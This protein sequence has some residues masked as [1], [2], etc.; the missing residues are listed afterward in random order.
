M[1]VI[2]G[3]TRS[4]VE[5]FEK[6][7][8]L[9]TNEDQVTVVSSPVVPEVNKIPTPEVDKTPPPEVDKTPTIQVYI[10]FE[11]FVLNHMLVYF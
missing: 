2:R 11:H 6:R 5:R 8:Q 1:A 3:R 4:L 7:E 10:S 9:S